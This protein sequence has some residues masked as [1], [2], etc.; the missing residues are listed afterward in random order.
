VAY[1][2]YLRAGNPGIQGIGFVLTPNDPYVA[3]DLDACVQRD[4][5]DDTA[6]QIVAESDSYTEIS[7]SGQGL[8]ILLA[9][10][11]FHDN[12][13]RA[14][15]ELY[16]HNRSVTIT[17]HHVA[18][19]PPTIS[20]VPPE[21]IA[22]LLPPRPEH[23][24]SPPPPASRL[25]QYAISDRELWEHIFAHDQY[26]HQHL[27]RFHGDRSLDPGDHS[28]TVIRLLNCLAH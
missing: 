4:E 16:S 5:L 18:G 21:L 28:F 22:S 20:S 15:I 7:P 9:C 17:G 8:R 3:V 26:G 14:A 23:A 10:S 12:R 11:A 6:A 13:R 2:A 27:Q 25:E 24:F 19:T 1:A